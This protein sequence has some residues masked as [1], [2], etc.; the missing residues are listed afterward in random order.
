MAHGKEAAGVHEGHAAHD[1]HDADDGQVHAHVSSVKF[2]VG[3]LSILVAF[4][5]LTVAVASVH[6]GPL[7]L[8]VA[9]AIASAKATLVVMFF[10]HLKYD[11]R[12]N[13]TIV[14]CSLMF[15]GVFFAYTMNDT[16]TRAELDDAQGSQV[17]PSSGVQ[18]PGGMVG[19]VSSH[20]SHERKGSFYA[21]NAGEPDD[22]APEPS[23]SAAA[24]EPAAGEVPMH[25]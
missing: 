12:F 6:L 15:I 17:L 7:N 4:T 21:P 1:D 19:S 20:R 13:A 9:I 25:K 8:A 3:I 2:Y 23:S 5:L 11:N 22:V 18:A 14:I 10:M 16:D 24:T